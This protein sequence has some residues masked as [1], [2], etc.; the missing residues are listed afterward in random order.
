[1]TPSEYLNS[2][3]EDQT[4]KDDS[5]ELKDLQTERQKVEK[6]L[7]EAFSGG[8]LT[9]RYGGSKAKGTLIRDSYDL[10]ILCYLAN[11]DNSGGET[12]EDIYNNAKKALEKDYNV[13]PK[14]SALRISNKEKVDFHIDVV[15]GRFSDDSKTDAFLFQAEGEKKALKTNPDKH[16]SHVK[17][18]GLLGTIKLLKL[19]KYRAGLDVKT[20]VLELLIIEALEKVTDEKGLEKCL[21][22]MW[23][24][25]AEK[26]GDIKIEDP[27]NPAGN[28]LSG[29]FDDALKLK[30]SIAAK[31]A[32]AKVKDNKWGEIFG[33]PVAPAERARVVASVSDKLRASGP[34][35]WF[36]Y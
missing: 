4:L 13:T 5:Q 20:F 17:N 31:Q 26:I 29:M 3:L 33:T 36:P 24:K 8:E 27:A 19:W 34:K 35:P 30:L 28:D 16:I 21:I 15:A 11:G 22:A 7:R 12:L 14:R 18:S 2:V 32:L 23:S 25:L 1:M 9:I 10:D 6:L